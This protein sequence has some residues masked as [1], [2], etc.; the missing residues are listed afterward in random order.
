MAKNVLPAQSLKGYEN[1]ST[2]FSKDA[3]SLTTYGCVL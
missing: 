3:E 2:C 1:I